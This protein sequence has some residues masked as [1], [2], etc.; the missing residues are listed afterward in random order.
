MCFNVFLCP[1]H[2]LG[3]SSS[4]FPINFKAP[5]LFCPDFSW[6]GCGGDFFSGENI[7]RFL[8]FCYY[9]FSA[10]QAALAFLI[11]MATPVAGCSLVTQVGRYKTK[12]LLSLPAHKN[13]PQEK[14]LQ[15]NKAQCA[16]AH[17]PSPGRRGIS[18]ALLDREET[19]TYSSVQEESNQWWPS[20]MIK[21]CVV[22][23]KGWGE[24]LWV[25]TWNDIDAMAL[26][27]ETQV[28]E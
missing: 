4:H 7:T 16:V 20:H 28:P 15:E 25:L 9:S 8:A 13:S 2:W 5:R 12:E 21:D 6:W 1:F 27:E 3:P 11:S 10:Q 17:V 14:P 23:K 26:S 19:A 24:N 22:S 18:K